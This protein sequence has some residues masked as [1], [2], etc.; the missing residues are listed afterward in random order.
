MPEKYNY[1]KDLVKITSG[2]LLCSYV[3]V[4]SGPWESSTDL[5]FS[6]WSVVYENANKI[7]ELK[8]IKSLLE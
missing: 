2:R 3:Y 5:V 6:G 7:A 1:L 8:P 4:S